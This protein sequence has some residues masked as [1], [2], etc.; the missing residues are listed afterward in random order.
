MLYPSFSSAAANA[1]HLTSVNFGLDDEDRGGN[2][3]DEDGG[4]RGPK[5]SGVSAEQMFESICNQR[6]AGGQLQLNDGNSHR[7]AYYALM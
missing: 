6:E 5:T 2:E 3:A 4:G 1:R 7:A